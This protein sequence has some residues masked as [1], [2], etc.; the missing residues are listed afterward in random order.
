MV[1]LQQ[2]A[3]LCICGCVHGPRGGA[4][5]AGAPVRRKRAKRRRAQRLRAPVLA[6]R[7]ARV[8]AQLY[9]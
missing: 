7:R 8:H 4:V 1:C 5:P 2:E 3:S 9:E 6:A